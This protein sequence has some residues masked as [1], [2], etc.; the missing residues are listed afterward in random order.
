MKKITHLRIW[1]PLAVCV[2]AFL[3]AA[4]GQHDQP[5]PASEVDSEAAVEPAAKVS[6]TTASDEARELYLQGRA[7]IDNLHVAEANEVFAQAVQADD[8]FAM[9]YFMLAQTAQ[10]AA[11][12]F[13]ATGKADEFSGGVSEGEKLYI[14]ALVATSKNDQAGQLDAL[15]QLIALYPQDERTHTQLGNYLSGQTGFYRRH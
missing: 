12:F 15:T 4:C 10:S 13:D 2:A 5:A 6:I 8:G 11:G 3:L 14:R 9:G 1:R 7:L